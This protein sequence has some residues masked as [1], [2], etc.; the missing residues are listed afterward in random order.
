V[1]LDHCQID[2]F[3]DE[4]DE[5]RRVLDESI[6]MTMGDRDAEELGRLRYER[7]AVEM[8]ARQLRGE[9]GE[10]ERR[11]VVCGPARLMAELITGAARDVS[12]RLVDQ[13]DV[14]PVDAD[15]LRA[16][17]RLVNVWTETYVAKETVE[18]YSFDPEFD[19]RQP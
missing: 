1:E 5:H 13:F 15:A 17:A 14:R 19:P 8:V 4:L 10:D 2:S 16:S 18:S 9:S 11:P 12:A 3:A 7:D 6:G